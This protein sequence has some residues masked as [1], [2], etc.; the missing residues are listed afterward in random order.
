MLIYFQPFFRN[1]VYYEYVGVANHSTFY[2]VAI[3]SVVQG[4]QSLLKKSISKNNQH[5]YDNLL[6]DMT[7]FSLREVNL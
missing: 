2:Y 6:K 1:G 3:R 5:H 4:I 7:F